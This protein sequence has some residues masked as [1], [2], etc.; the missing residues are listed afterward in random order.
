MPDWSSRTWSAPYVF[1]HA[2]DHDS[3]A[4][5]PE[6]QNRGILI[7]PRAARCQHRR[8][9]DRDNSDFH[10]RVLFLSFTPGSSS[11]VNSTPPFSRAFLT[12]C[13]F[14]ACMLGMPS[15]FSAFC[16]VPKD[17]PHAFASL[18][19]VSRR[20]QHSAEARISYR[21][22]SR[23]HRS[24]DRLL[25]VGAGASHF[26][27]LARSSMDHRSIKAAAHRSGHRGDVE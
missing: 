15:S 22:G 21:R 2:T 19:A 24:G 12:A 23:S 4:R 3:P 17:S 26:G 11:F 7:G 13:K 27:D 10:F 8:R 5:W 14:F 18:S 20:R 25:Q 16:I 1:D 9:R 6:I